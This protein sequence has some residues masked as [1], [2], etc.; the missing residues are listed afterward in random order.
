[1]LSISADRRRVVVPWYA[2]LVIVVLLSLS[3]YPSIFRV[4]QSHRRS[5]LSVPLCRSLA[6]ISTSAH[7]EGLDLDQRVLLSL[8]RGKI[9]EPSPFRLRGAASSIAAAASMLV[10]DLL[11]VIP[12]PPLPR[13]FFSLCP[14]SLLVLPLWPI[15]E[16]AGHKS[17]ATPAR[18][19][20]PTGYTTVNRAPCPSVYV[21]VRVFRSRPVRST[22]RNGI[23][24][25]GGAIDRSLYAY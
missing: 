5:A 23:A 21:Y 3:L 10:L 1:M 14:S 24:A 15:E 8:P 13:S 6:R 11:I 16:R 19:C 17:G 25:I 22:P 7:T 2:R 9:E 18:D 20:N 12:R 4:S